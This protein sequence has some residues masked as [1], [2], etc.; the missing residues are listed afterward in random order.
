MNAEPAVTH[1]RPQTPP[2]AQSAK[3]REDAET[4]SAADNFHQQ[5][6]AQPSSPLQPKKKKSRPTATYAGGSASNI[7][8]GMLA[9][10]AL[11]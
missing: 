1:A 3:E 4:P 9:N 8:H 7:S 10:Y 5:P 6:Q 2:T 11:L